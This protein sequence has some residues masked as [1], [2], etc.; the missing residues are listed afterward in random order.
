MIS[1]TR[2]TDLDKKTATTPSKFG[3]S[4]AAAIKSVCPVDSTG[5]KMT[6][7]TVDKEGNVSTNA[8]L[9]TATTRAAFEKAMSSVIGQILKNPSRKIGG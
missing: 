2:K 9:T 1:I 5:L 4:L 3:D 6:Q 7:V 8:L